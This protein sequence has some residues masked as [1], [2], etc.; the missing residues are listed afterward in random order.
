MKSIIWYVKNGQPPTAGN[1]I[2]RQKLLL[3]NGS[4][5]KDFA[6]GKKNPAAMWQRDCSREIHFP[7]LSFVPVGK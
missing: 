2:F 4:M 3:C 5:G 7:T 6:E 1:A